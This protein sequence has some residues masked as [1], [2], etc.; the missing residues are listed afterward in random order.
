MAVPL[1]VGWQATV[2]GLVNLPLLNGA[3]VRLRENLGERWRVTYEVDG[4][5]LTYN[6]RPANLTGVDPE[7]EAR[8]LLRDRGKPT[9]EAYVQ[10]QIRKMAGIAQNPEP[11]AEQVAHRMKKGGGAVVTG[12]TE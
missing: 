11:A 5:R 6:I 3:T 1:V 7:P 9:S 2:Q 10:W 4:E 12:L 8:Q